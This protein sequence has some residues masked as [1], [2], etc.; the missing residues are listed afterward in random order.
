[1]PRLTQDSYTGVMSYYIK[2]CFRRLGID[3]KHCKLC[4]KNIKRPEFHH[5]KYDGATIYDL[6][7]VCHRCNMLPENINL[8]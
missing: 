2:E 8:K 1:M 4:G 3:L 7:V 5:T 6:I